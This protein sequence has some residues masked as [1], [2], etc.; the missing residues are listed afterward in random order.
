MSGRKMMFAAVALLA[1]TMNASAHHSAVQFDFTR[2]VPIK[3]KVTLFRAINPHMQLVLQVKDARGQ[4][5]VTLEGHST[6]NMY[7]GGYRKGM[8][9]AGDVIT[10]YVA[11][12]KGG[13]EGG[14]VLWAKTASGETFG[15][16]AS[17]QVPASTQAQ[18]EGK[19]A[20]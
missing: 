4:H 12:L 13:A 14:F 18:T 11:P 17:A 16:P 2:E 1:A 19:A 6:N 10:V 20:R 8:I 15:R 3:G 9:K 5:E 7:R